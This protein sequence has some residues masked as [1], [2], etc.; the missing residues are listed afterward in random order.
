MGDQQRRRPRPQQPGAFSLVHSS[1]VSIPF[2]DFVVHPAGVVAVL[3]VGVIFFAG[4]VVR[5]CTRRREAVRGF[6]PIVPP[7]DAAL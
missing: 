1:A 7:D 5:W 4:D 2:T 3:V 6:E